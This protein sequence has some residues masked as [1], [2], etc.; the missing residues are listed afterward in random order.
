MNQEATSFII[1]E[2]VSRIKYLT[3][4]EDPFM[5]DNTYEKSLVTLYLIYIKLL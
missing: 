2:I 1:S 5:C 3:L 4:V